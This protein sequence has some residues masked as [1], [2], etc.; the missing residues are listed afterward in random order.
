MGAGGVSGF[1]DF[2]VRFPGW[3]RS[4]DLGWDRSCRARGLGLVLRLGCHL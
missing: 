2:Q 3:R 4:A 1:W